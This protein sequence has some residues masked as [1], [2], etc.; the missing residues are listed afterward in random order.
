MQFNSLSPGVLNTFDG[1]NESGCT[2][3]LRLIQ[4]APAVYR[5]TQWPRARRRTRAEATPI[6]SIASVCFFFFFDRG[7]EFLLLLEFQIDMM[8]SYPVIHWSSLYLSL[9]FFFV[10]KFYGDFFFCS[11]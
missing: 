6:L 2:S 8:L 4:M 10:F 9:D 3:G 7:L 11:F 1:D 5:L